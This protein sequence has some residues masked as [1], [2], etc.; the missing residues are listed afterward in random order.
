[1]ATEG[2]AYP[3][4]MSETTPEEL[5]DVLDMVR[6]LAQQE[7]DEL[8]VALPGEA[9]HEEKLID[10]ETLLDLIAQHLKPLGWGIAGSAEEGV[11]VF[12]R[13]A[14]PS[15]WATVLVLALIVGLV[16]VALALFD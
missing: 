5:A 1:M 12:Q 13:I 7:A 3:A 6:N 9:A 4:L 10:H 14:R 8:V 11:Y 16:A 15:A 2:R